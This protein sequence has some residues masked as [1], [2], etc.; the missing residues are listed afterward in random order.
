MLQ[1]GRLTRYGSEVD[2]KNAER[3]EIAK[4]IDELEKRQAEIEADRAASQKLAE[5]RREDGRQL[6][7]EIEQLRKDR[8]A[9]Q[10]QITEVKS[11]L[12]SEE[13]KLDKI[14]DLRKEWEKRTA[15][16]ADLADKTREGENRISEL[17]EIEK[18]LM[19]QIAK[20][21][22]SLESQANLV[23]RSEKEMLALV[24]QSG[25]RSDEIE[26]KKEEVNRLQIEKTDLEDEIG[27]YRMEEARLRR[28]TEDLKKRNAEASSTL[29]SG[30]CGCEE[31]T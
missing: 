2:A 29:G 12:A 20:S 8:I 26:R 23:A 7:L 18:N 14:N 19:S 27:D 10:D 11:R 21:K 28:V 22:A 9:A 4:S 25:M 6:R 16:I 13:N 1:K 24:E 17:E 3:K 30:S 15:K 5:T 31:G